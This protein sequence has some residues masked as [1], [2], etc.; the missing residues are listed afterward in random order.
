LAI[1]LC[2]SKTI[3]LKENHKE[4]SWVAVGEEPVERCRNEEEFGQ[5]TSER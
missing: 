3:F 1:K 4:A 5:T 2:F